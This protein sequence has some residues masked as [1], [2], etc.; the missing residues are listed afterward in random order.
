MKQYPF[1]R[2]VKPPLLIEPCA[3]FQ[4]SGKALLARSLVNSSERVAVRL[5]NTSNQSQTIFKN[6]VEGVT[7]PVREVLVPKREGIINHVMPVE[8]EE[9]LSEHMMELF[10]RTKAGLT[11]E[12]MTKVQNILIRFS[13]IFSKSKDDYGR[14]SLI[15]HQ[16]NTEGQKPTKQSPEGY[17]IMLRNSL[18]KRLKILL[19][20]AL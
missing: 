17:R 14:T 15:K 19:P 18:T 9:K 5:M 16:I 11:E 7:S 12:Q 6:T 1:P 8:N 13:H 3:K 4:D 2:E 10:D 20:K